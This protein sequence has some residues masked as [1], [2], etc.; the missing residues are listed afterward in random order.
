MS[1]A[2][3]GTWSKS[4]AWRTTKNYT[5]EII[6]SC[7][8]DIW[9]IFVHLCH[10]KKYVNTDYDAH[11]KSRRF[12]SHIGHGMTLITWVSWVTW[13]IDY[14][15]SQYGKKTKFM[16]RHRFWD[17]FQLSDFSISEPSNPSRETVVAVAIAYRFALEKRSV[18]DPF[19]TPKV[20]DRWSTAPHNMFHSYSRIQYINYI[21]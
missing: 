14:S 6:N 7:L 13:D 18:L 21:N 17:G 9:L 20:E 1:D 2:G 11:I 8:I 12:Q 10:N 19:A 4:K 5:C 3:V 15:S 16:K